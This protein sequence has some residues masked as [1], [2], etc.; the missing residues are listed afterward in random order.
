[1]KPHNAA[2][3]QENIDIPYMEK[4]LARSIIERVQHKYEYQDNNNQPVGDIVRVVQP[5][6]PL[7][8]HDHKGK[9]K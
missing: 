4:R 6:K 2:L 7:L 8:N 5:H 3:D 9:Q 1:M